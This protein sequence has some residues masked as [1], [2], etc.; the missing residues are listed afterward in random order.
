MYVVDDSG[1]QCSA[2]VV[3]SEALLTVDQ[4][5]VD[6]AHARVLPQHVVEGIPDPLRLVAAHAA[7]RA[8]LCNAQALASWQ[9]VHLPVPKVVHIAEPLPLLVPVV[10]ASSVVGAA[11]DGVY[12]LA[13]WPPL[14]VAGL[15]VAGVRAVVRQLRSDRG[16]CPAKGVHN[17]PV[18][19]LEGVLAVSAAAPC[20]PVVPVSIELVQRPDGDLAASVADVVG[21]V[22]DEAIVLAVGNVPQVGVGVKEL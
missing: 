13:P 5:P 14:P 22:L 3:S 9:S 20:A 10:R 4:E 8:R 7:G 12:H 15:C 1:E 16:P 19:C 6:S 21:E 11:S 2:G 18:G 17:L